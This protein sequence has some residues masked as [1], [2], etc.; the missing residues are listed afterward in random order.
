LY[1]LAG[2][3]IAGSERVISSRKSQYGRTAFVSSIF[4]FPNEFVMSSCIIGF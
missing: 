4:Y 2:Q 3:G 1:I